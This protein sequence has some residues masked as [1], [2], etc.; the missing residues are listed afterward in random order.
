MVNLIV[1]QQVWERYRR[2]ARSAVVMLA[3][4]YL[5]REAG[6]I[7]LLATRLEDL[8][9]LPMLDCCNTHCVQLAE[10][11]YRHAGYDR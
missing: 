5:Q 10:Y 8:S 7:H 4:G 6:V 1:G 2:A 3:H 11:I 9:A